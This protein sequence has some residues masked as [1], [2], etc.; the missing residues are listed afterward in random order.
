MAGDF[1][2][3]FEDRVVSCRS[4]IL[5]KYSGLSLCYVRRVDRLSASIYMLLYLSL[6]LKDEEEQAEDSRREV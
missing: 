2:E 5:L 1:Y 4:R 6:R 3:K